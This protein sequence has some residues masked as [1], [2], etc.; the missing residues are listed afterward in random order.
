MLAV[1][2][3]LIDHINPSGHITVYYHLLDSDE[4]GRS[5]IQN[6]FNKNSKTP[7]QIIAKSGDKVESVTYVFLFN[8]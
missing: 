4:N 2:D 3:C 8:L 1:L 7:F 5:P 6:G